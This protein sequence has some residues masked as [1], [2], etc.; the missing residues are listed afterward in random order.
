MK[1]HIYIIGLLILSSSCGDSFLDVKRDITQVI[2]SKIEDYQS[3]LDK[4]GVINDKASISLGLVG[5]AEYSLTDNALTTWRSMMPY[6]ITGYLWEEEIFDGYESTDWNNAYHRILYANMALE[7]TDIKPTPNEQKAWDNVVGGALFIRAYSYYQLAQLFCK[8][9]DPQTAGQ[10]LGVPLKKNRDVTEKLSRSSVKEVYSLILEDLQKAYQLLP[11][12]STSVFRPQKTSAAVLLTRA[13]MQMGDYPNALKYA[14]IAYQSPQQLQHYSYINPD[15]GGFPTDYGSSN[16]EVIFYSA[17][18]KPS[19]T[20]TD[21][22][23]SKEIINLYEHNDLR[24]N[25]FFHPT[26]DGRLE[27]KGSFAGLY[28]N[29]AGIA[30]GE[31][32]LNYAEC[33]ARNGQIPRGNEILNEL[34]K[35]RFATNSFK[36]VNKQN[37]TEL[38][39][40]IFEERRRELYFKGLAWED[41]RR[42]NKE[43]EIITT[44]KRE[45]Y[46]KVYTLEPNSNRWVWPLPDNEV[47]IN[48]Y[49]QNPR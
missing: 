9:Y 31:I 18:N 42:F 29:F 8:P 19:S 30:S 6:E 17:I 23:V 27:F 39:K 22:D 41:Y 5:A 33:L 21:T 4:F 36:A 15:H 2:P 16:P 40:Y 35:M 7:V 24:L 10:D 46:D 14:E 44:L 1:F 28:S 43:G 32:Y 26:K 3:L 13:Y 38:I 45:A 25:V 47:E 34:R 11:E 48:K 49:Q 20:Y 37:Y 12:K